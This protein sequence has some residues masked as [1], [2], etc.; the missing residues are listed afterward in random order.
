MITTPLI[1]PLLSRPTGYVLRYL[2]ARQRSWQRRGA[3][4]R[5]LLQ[6]DNSRHFA[7]LEI[8]LRPCSRERKR[9]MWN[10]WFETNEVKWLKLI[11]VLCDFWLDGSGNRLQT[12]KKRKR[13]KDI[14]IT[15]I[16]NTYTH[17]HMCTCTAPVYFNR[18][19]PIYRDPAQT[20][21]DLSPWLHPNIQARCRDTMLN[22]PA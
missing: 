7:E 6:K 12:S 10:S 3:T 18:E 15:S 1:T 5:Y 17:T 2:R 19:T 13:K 16:T 9:V 22:L 21:R 11:L 20:Y 8:F 4:A 14:N